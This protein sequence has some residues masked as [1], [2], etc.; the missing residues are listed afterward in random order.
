M[1]G[2]MLARRARIR[3]ATH[4]WLDRGPD[5]A[6]RR[7]RVGAERRDRGNAHD[8]D[9]RQHDGILDRRGAVF[10]FEE[11]DDLFGGS[12]RQLLHGRFLTGGQDGLGKLNAQR[13]LG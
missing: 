7:I 8:H 9:Q 6:E 3:L 5:V 12:T 4:G 10:L 11:L 2:I 13:R 1:N